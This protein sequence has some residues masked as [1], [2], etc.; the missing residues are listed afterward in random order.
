MRPL[1]A[2]T[3]TFFLI[4]GVFA[5]TQFADSVRREAIEYEVDF[6]RQEYSVEIRKSFSAAPDPI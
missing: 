6:S 5:Y 2:L 1:L 4:G 3:I